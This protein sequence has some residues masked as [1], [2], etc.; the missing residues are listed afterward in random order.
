[1]FVFYGALCVHLRFVSRSF[2]MYNPDTWCAVPGFR[3]EFLVRILGSSC[4]LEH[5]LEHDVARKAFETHL[6]TE[7][8][9][10]ALMSTQRASYNLTCTSLTQLQILP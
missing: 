6:E 4:H 5:V 2:S 3:A 1:M 10:E 9:K 8:A 7:Y